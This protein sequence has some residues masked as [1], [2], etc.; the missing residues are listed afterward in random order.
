M[1]RYYF[2][3]TSA[4]N[5]QSILKNGICCHT[6]NKI[7]NCS[8][9]EVYLWDI[10][11]VAKADCIETE[12]KYEK[13]YATFRAASESGQLA[14]CLAKDCRIVVIKVLLDDREIGVD[15]SCDN[16]EGRGAVVINRDILP[17]EIIEI[18]ISN[19][20][21]LVKGYFLSLLKN[22]Q[23]CGVE[24]SHIET[25]ISDCFSKAEIYID[26]I[27]DL[28]SFEKIPIKKPLINSLTNSSRS[29]KL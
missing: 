18:Q 29:I 19:D 17:S 25:K 24:F 27:N 10:E 28:I 22:N 8:G 20:L 4:D 9:N 2:H 3:G 1:K 6:D 14:L 15:L 23:F 12:S 5:L 13:E 16:M 11:G 26:D 7:W 21:S